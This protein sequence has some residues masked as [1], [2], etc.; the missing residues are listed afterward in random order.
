[1]Q[2]NEKKCLEFH[3]KKTLIWD[4]VEMYH[5]FRSAEKASAQSTPPSHRKLVESSRPA[6]QGVDPKW[7][8]SWGWIPVKYILTFFFLQNFK[9]YSY[10][11]VF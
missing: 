9:S 3:F 5:R 2:I 1:M 7:R 10:S 8:T 4:E 6:L 11:F